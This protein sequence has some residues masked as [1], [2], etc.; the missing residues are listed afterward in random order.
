MFGYV[1][2]LNGWTDLYSYSVLNS[3]SIPDGCLVDLNIPA[4]KIGDFQMG[5]KAQNRNFLENSS[6]LIT[7]Q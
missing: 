5:S 6:T 4:P 2:H 7:F 3:L 1:P